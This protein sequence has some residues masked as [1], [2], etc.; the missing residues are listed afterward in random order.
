MMKY[1]HV[2]MY[3][4][5]YVYTYTCVFIYIC[6]CA[7]I[8]S[9]SM[10]VD[11]WMRWAKPLPLPLHSPPRTNQQ[12]ER[13]AA[14]QSWPRRCRRMASRPRPLL[15]RVDVIGWSGSL[16]ADHCCWVSISFYKYQ[17]L[18]VATNIY[19]RRLVFSTSCLFSLGWGTSGVSFSLLDNIL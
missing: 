16:P 6:I 2:Y 18:L 13:H 1:I 12:R 8:Q 17:L 10:S 7:C 14:A 11:G 19:W 15:L 9:V 4:Y 3:I 5:I